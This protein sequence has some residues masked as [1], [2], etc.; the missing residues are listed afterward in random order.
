MKV[1]IAFGTRPWLIGLGLA[2]VMIAAASPDPARATDRGAYEATARRFIVRDCSDLHCFRVLVPW[3][4]GALPGPSLLKWKAYAVAANWLAALGVYA[5]S[6]AWGLSARAALMAAVMS[7]LGFGSLYTLFDPFTSD[8][9]M[10]AIGPFLAWLVLHD[11]L[12]IAGAVA[13]IGV[14]AKEFAAAPMLIAAAATAA[15]G[16]ITEALRVAAFANVALIAW[17]TLQLVLII[18]FNYSYAGNA[19]TQLLSGGYLGYWL[20]RQSW[21]VSAMAIYGEFGVLWLLAPAGL[22]LAPPAMRRFAIAATPVALV[23]AYVQQPD[24][25][26]WNFHFIATP[27]AAL[28]L[29]RA[30]AVAAWVCVAAFALANFRLGAQLAHVPAARAS[31]AISLIV[32]FGCLYGLRRASPL[33]TAAR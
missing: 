23:F 27:L 31:L 11:R 13:A 30:P 26:F 22:W 17:L 14:L 3:V 5:L 8:P 9:L 28:V 24:R 4:L 2:L 15:S 10:Y 19:S 20:S 7:A 16:R 18:A 32:A 12:A 33:V 25:A 21:A 29:E 1:L 6:I